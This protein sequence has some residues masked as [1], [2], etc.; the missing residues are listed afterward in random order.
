MEESVF[1]TKELNEGSTTRPTIGSVLD[2]RKALQW[3]L[4]KDYVTA[5]VPGMTARSQLDL[6]VQ[7]LGSLA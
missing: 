2:H 3:V 1:R 6:N 5:A 4:S 7:T